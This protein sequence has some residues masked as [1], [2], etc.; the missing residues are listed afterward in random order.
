MCH[1]TPSSSNFEVGVG[2]A[3]SDVRTIQGLK[4]PL[5]TTFFRDLP[6]LTFR[7]FLSNIGDNR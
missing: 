5:I 1:V 3:D 6:R 7:R 4:I 2:L